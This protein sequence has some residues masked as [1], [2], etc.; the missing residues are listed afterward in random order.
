MEKASMGFAGRQKSKTDKHLLPVNFSEQNNI[1]FGL[2][3][4][5]RNKLANSSENYYTLH[6]EN[7]CT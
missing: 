1:M 6:M 4:E 7:K 5:H 3:L 2:L